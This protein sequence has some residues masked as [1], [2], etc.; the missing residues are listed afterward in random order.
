MAWHD[1]R[2]EPS[3]FVQ[4]SV[5]RQACALNCE[6][7]SVYNTYTSLTSKD[8]NQTFSLTYGD[9]STVEGDQY[10]DTVTVSGLTAENQTVGAAVSYSEG[11]AIRNFPADGLV[12]MAFPEISSFGAEPLFHSLVAQNQTVAPQFGFKLAE[13]GSELF[14]GGVNTDLIKGDL[15]Y[16][17]V[18]QQGFWQ[19]NL[20]AVSLDGFPTSTNQSAIVDTG[21][22]LVL[23]DSKSVTDFYSLIPGAK[24]A[25][26]TVGEGFFTFPCQSALNITLTFGGQPFPISPETFNLGQAFAGSKDCVGGIAAFDLL[27]VWIVGDV[28]LQNV[29][30]VFDVGNNTVGFAA[31]VESESEPEPEP[32]W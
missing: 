9:G 6:G 24:P 3:G 22:T 14:L 26:Q 25:S 31:L 11:F 2:W 29:Y 12:G 20:E 7:H 16:T 30:T 4:R 28:F 23:G 10:T 13:N 18:I 1:F 21:T 15:V 17:P 19:V 27:D 32:S 5:T 8:L